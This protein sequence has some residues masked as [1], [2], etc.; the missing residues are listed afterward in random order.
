MIRRVSS[1]AAVEQRLAGVVG[2]DNKERVGADRNNTAHRECDNISS[3]RGSGRATE[4]V[5]SEE[6]KNPTFVVAAPEE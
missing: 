2:C 1:T 6:M 3:Y 4:I 5:D